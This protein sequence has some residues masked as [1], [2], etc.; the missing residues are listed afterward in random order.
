MTVDSAEIKDH[1]PCLNCQNKIYIH[2]NSMVEGVDLNEDLTTVYKINDDGFSKLFIS[3]DNIEEQRC[4]TRVFDKNFYSVVS[5]PND[6]KDI[7]EASSN[8][9]SDNHLPISHSA[10][11]NQYLYKANPT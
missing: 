8:N 7:M 10:Y 5:S 11:L 2:P 4:L 6:V 1:Y 3:F 9:V